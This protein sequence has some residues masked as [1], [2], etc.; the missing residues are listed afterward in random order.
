M[1]GRK[2][3]DED[4]DE[5][6]SPEST[7]PSNSR[8]GS[9][10]RPPENRQ[11]GANNPVNRDTIINE[12]NKSNEYLSALPPSSSTKRPP[13]ISIPISPSLAVRHH[14]NGDIPSSPSSNGKA[15]KEFTAD[16]P[17][18][19]PRGISTTAKLPSPSKAQKN[20]PINKENHP[21]AEPVSPVNEPQ[22][23]QRHKSRNHRRRMTEE[24]AIK[25]LG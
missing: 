14:G 15:R 22:P 7:T 1:T 9:P 17:P 13:N 20:L 21:T 2:S 8:P 10:T 24:E 25:E 18:K 4:E 12:D 16:L 5:Y 11:I 6:H 3:D 19:V 23:I